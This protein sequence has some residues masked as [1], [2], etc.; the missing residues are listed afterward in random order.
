M[1]RSSRQGITGHLFSTFPNNWKDLTREW[2][3]RVDRASKFQQRS[4]AC[5]WQF[6]RWRSFCNR[7]QRVARRQAKKLQLYG[8]AYAH[9]QLAA[10]IQHWQQHTKKRR[11]EKFTLER[12]YKYQ[13]VR[14]LKFGTHTWKAAHLVRR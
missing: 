13:M 1:V 8:A 7:T 2:L 10:A 12:A 11:R 4:L 9:N 3:A 5:W 14:D 6:R